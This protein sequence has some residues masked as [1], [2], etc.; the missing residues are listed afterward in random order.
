MTHNE[1]F[2]MQQMLN[3]TL[4]PPNRNSRIYPNDALKKALVEYEKMIKRREREKKLNE[5][6]NE[7]PNRTDTK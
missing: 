1:L 2:L 4:I 6:F 5:I 3:P 7:T